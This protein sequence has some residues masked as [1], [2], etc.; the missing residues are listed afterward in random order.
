MSSDL[1]LKQL[2]LVV[3]SFAVRN[4]NKCI[5]HLKKV[6]FLSKPLKN[7][8]LFI[9]N[10]ASAL[11]SFESLAP[12]KISKELLLTRFQMSE[13]ELSYVFDRTVDRDEYFASLT[14][15]GEILSKQSLKVTA[16]IKQAEQ[17]LQVYQSLSSSGGME[18]LSSLSEI[19]DRFVTELHERASSKE[20][21][22]GLKTG[23]E[24][25]DET[26]NGFEKNKYYV[27]AARPAMGK[28]S[29]ALSIS[30]NIATLNKGAHVLIFS[31]EMPKVE[32]FRR[33]VASYCGINNQGLKRG[34]LTKKEQES[35]DRLLP[36][37]NSLKITICD[38]YKLTAEDAHE[39]AMEIHE[40]DPVDLIVADYFQKFETR[41]KYS[42][43]NDSLEKV[44]NIFKDMTS[45]A[46]VLLLAQLNR[47]LE[48]RPDKRPIPSDL[49]GS[50]A[51]EQDADAIMFLYRDVIYNPNTIDPS[52]AE[53]IIPKNR[54]GSTATIE[55]VFV[56]ENVK[57][58]SRDS[59]LMRAATPQITQ[60][61]DLNS[62]DDMLYL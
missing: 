14:I 56:Q 15:L 47:D 55:I 7:Q 33:M 59:L 19:S 29:F 11:A 23:F 53:L 44:S 48:K 32:L 38:D 54:D 27:L 30:L 5:P 9:Y 12:N 61:N 20:T 10:A 40:K 34:C 1:N 36:V 25:I 13:S 60:P 57:F 46:T 31:K 8:E 21:V 41:G 58:T 16:D 18:S 37:L 6:Q 35:L 42:T 4:Y 50:G 26:L 3:A 17:I 45:I 49:R 51:L 24:S 39:M 43:T 28:T 52:A 2:F 22:F 62:T